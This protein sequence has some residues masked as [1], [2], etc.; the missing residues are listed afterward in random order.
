MIGSISVSRLACC[1]FMTVLRY[2]VAC[3]F[4]NVWCEQFLVNTKT[5]VHSFIYAAPSKLTCTFV[6]NKELIEILSRINYLRC[7]A[8]AFGW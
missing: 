8:K 5:H 7:A 3:T 1:L 2:K 6:P 4:W